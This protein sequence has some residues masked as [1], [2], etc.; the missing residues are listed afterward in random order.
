[1]KDLR[2]TGHEA[3]AI[4][5]ENLE[6]ESFKLAVDESVKAAVRSAMAGSQSVDAISPREIQDRVRS[7]ATVEEIVAISGASKEYVEKFAQPV[8]DELTHIVEAA[9]AVRITIAGDRFNDEVQEEF[10]RII[11]SRLFASGATNVTWSSRRTD[12]GI[13]HVS[14][15]FEVTGESGQAVWQFEPRKFVLSPENETAV[16]LSN[17]DSSLDGPIPKLRPVLKTTA[18]PAEEDR[19]ATVTQLP[20]SKPSTFEPEPTAVEPEANFDV[21]A[22]FRKPEEAPI[23]RLAEMQRSREDA[24][25]REVEIAAQESSTEFESE[26][27]TNTDEPQV[28]QEVAPPVEN[29]DDDEI[30]TAKDSKKGRAT[31]P[32][33]DEIVF[34][35]KADD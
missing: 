13:W 35:T 27:M 6:G 30:N 17:H 16:T 14:A 26:D 33:W 1:M 19:T 12:V 31:M 15:T 32:S 28:E 2:L 3:G 23:D 11:Q 29:V 25:L 9:L 24:Q 7:G 22:A 4:L 21:P 18:K 8:L 20:F 34:G 10:G 5:L